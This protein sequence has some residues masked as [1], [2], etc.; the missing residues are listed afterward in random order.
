MFLG[1]FECAA[2]GRPGRHRLPEFVVAFYN[3]K[4][5]AERERSVR[6][7]VRCGNGEAGLGDLR[8]GLPQ[9]LVN[10]LLL[11]AADLARGRPRAAQA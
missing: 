1:M 3:A 9:R 11:R 7:D 10:F 5:Q 8:I 4:G 6:V 2:H